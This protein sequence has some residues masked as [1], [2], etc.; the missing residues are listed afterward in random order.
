MA[1]KRVKFTDQLRQAIENCGKT[2]Y[3]ISQDTGID[4]AI[5]SRFIHGKGGLSMPVLDVLGEYLGLHVKVEGKPR[6][7]K[8]K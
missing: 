7:P 4:Q 5:L 8:R 6:K 2:R 1:E 3:Q